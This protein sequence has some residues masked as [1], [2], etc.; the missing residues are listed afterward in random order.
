MFSI[1]YLTYLLT[2]VALF[3]LLGFSFN[4][5]KG[6]T[7]LLNLAHPGMILL[8]AYTTVL[9]QRAGVPLPLAWAAGAAA[10]LLLGAL[11]SVLTRRS[12]GDVLGVMALWCLFVLEIVALNWI[13]LTRGALGIPGIARPAGFETG[14]MF[15]LLTLIIVGIVYVFLHR[16][17][18]SPF[19]RVLGAV[20]DDELAA[21][22][23]GKNVFKARVVAFLVGGA[24]AGLGGGLFAMF[25][26]Y[27]DPPSFYIIQLVTIIA[28]VFVGGPASLP[29]TI[30]GALVVVILPELLRFLPF[31]PEVVGAL[32]QIVFSALVLAVI[33]LHP[34]GVLGKVEL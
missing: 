25:F 7:G 19:G 11:L 24:L 15:L 6:F 32:R 3:A 22:T 13:A 20:R 23:L 10:G 17:V 31:N 1:P 5:L 8:G 26:R 21:Q 12:R 33:V 34:R 2:L 27:I 16:V 18:S 4:L 30:V 9:L 28:I 14:P 29:G